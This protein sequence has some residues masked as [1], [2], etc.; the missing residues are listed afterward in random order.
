MHAAV[1][2]VQDEQD[3]DADDAMVHADLVGMKVRPPPS[4]PLVKSYCFAACCQMRVLH[5]VGC[6]LRC[7]ELCRFG[8]RLTNSAPARQPF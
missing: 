7:I 8:T 5:L 4:C 1:S 3:S 6:L 2:C